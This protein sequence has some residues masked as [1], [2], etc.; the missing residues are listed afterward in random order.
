M[1]K[2]VH[3]YLENRSWWQSI[4][5]RGYDGKRIGLGRPGAGSA[6]INT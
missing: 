3:W 2:T 6:S 4:I 5:Q 1:A